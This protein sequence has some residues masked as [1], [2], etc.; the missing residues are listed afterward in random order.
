MKDVPGIRYDKT[1]LFA[2]YLIRKR[3]EM[4]GRENTLKIKSVA[5]KDTIIGTRYSVRHLVSLTSA[6]IIKKFKTAPPMLI[7]KATSPARTDSSL[8]YTRLVSF[9]EKDKE[10]EVTSTGNQHSSL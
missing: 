4:I 2:S 3:R 6:R 8:E 9:S 1:C 10:S 5:A 7:K